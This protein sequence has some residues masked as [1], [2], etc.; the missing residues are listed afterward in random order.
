[1]HR[2]MLF[3]LILL[4][5]KSKSIALCILRENNNFLFNI[6]FHAFGWE[7]QQTAPWMYFLLSC[8]RLT[9]RSHILAQRVYNI[10][11]MRTDAREIGR[12]MKFGVHWKIIN[13]ISATLKR[14]SPNLS[15]AF[16][17]AGI[18]RFLH[19]IRDRIRELLC[20]KKPNQR[21]RQC[22]T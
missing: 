21:Q 5:I 6:N 14:K 10:T 8:A 20:E 3:D 9:C 17:Q 22:G 4:K 12:R 2:T 19:E 7:N 15:C 11:V 18:S 13:N 1:M 16:Y